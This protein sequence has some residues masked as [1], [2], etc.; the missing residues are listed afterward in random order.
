MVHGILEPNREADTEF[1]IGVGSGFLFEDGLGFDEG[2]V[3]GEIV[4]GEERG[5]DFEGV[6]LDDRVTAT[7]L[8]GFDDAAEADVANLGFEVV[9][10]KIGL[11]ADVVGPLDAVLIIGAGRGFETVGG[12]GEIGIDGGEIGLDGGEEVC[13]RRGAESGGVGASSRLFV[14]NCAEA[15]WASA[16]VKATRRR[17]FSRCVFM[18]ARWW[19]LVGWLG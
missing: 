14:V 17:I 12:P 2:E 16:T 13:G 6:V 3:A 11:G 1:K 5:L 10:V 8:E 19:L 15:R 9:G 4:A 7:G 18:V